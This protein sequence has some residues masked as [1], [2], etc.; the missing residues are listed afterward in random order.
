MAAPTRHPDRVRGAAGV[1]YHCPDV[2]EVDR[3]LK[4]LVGRIRRSQPEFPWVVLRWRYDADQLLDRRLEL[5]A[6]G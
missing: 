4:R 2:A 5:Q 3:H 1:L 6:Q